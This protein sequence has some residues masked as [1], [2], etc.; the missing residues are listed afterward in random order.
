[1]AFKD[2]ENERAAIT[3]VVKQVWP[4]IETTFLPT[5]AKYA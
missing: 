3:K 1:M 4:E 2:Y 5:R